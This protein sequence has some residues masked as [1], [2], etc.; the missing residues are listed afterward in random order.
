M[1]LWTLPDLCMLTCCTQATELESKDDREIVCSEIFADV[2]GL[3]D[4]RA[5]GM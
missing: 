5:C 2:S 3:A 1:A 4:A